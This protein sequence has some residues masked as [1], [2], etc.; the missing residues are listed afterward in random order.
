MPDNL[1]QNLV[2]PVSCPFYTLPPRGGAVNYSIT[3]S[4]GAF[5]NE[6]TGQFQPKF[7]SSLVLLRNN[8]TALETLLLQ[9][10]TQTALVVIRSGLLPTEPSSTSRIVG[11]SERILTTF[12]TATG[13]AFDASAIY[14]P[15]LT[16]AACESTPLADSV[17]VARYDLCS[18]NGKALCPIAVAGE[19]NLSLCKV[20]ATFLKTSMPDGS[21]FSFTFHEGHLR[22]LCKSEWVRDIIHTP[23]RINVTLRSGVTSL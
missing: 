13:S 7:D 2:S 17:D 1:L 9:A 16:N 11:A 15:S 18:E 14:N 3:F 22:S 5:H 10:V 6:N 19:T 23:L 4:P 20:S 12:P 8:F 21:L